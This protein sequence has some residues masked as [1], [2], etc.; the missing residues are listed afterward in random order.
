MR[1]SI[2]IGL[3]IF[4]FVSLAAV[5][6]SEAHPTN[7][8]FSR[9]SGPAQTL[10]LNSSKVPS[11]L[12]SSY[13]NNVS[14]NITTNLGNSVNLSFVNARTVNGGFVELANHGKIHNFNDGNQQVTGIN[15]I[16]FTGS[17]SFTF[18]PALAGGILPDITPIS[19]SA[20]GGQ[21]SIPACDYFE[22][23]AGD[24]GA[25]ITS[26][27]L[28]YSC[29]S[30]DYNVKL[31]NGTYTGKGGS[32]AYTYK[33]TIND[34]SAT[35]VSL[36]KQTNTSL[37]GTATMSSKTSL[38]VALTNLTYNFTYDGHALTYVS[39]SGSSASS[40]PEL[41]L[42]R[43]Y[44]VENFES[45]SIT[46]QGYTNS[47]TK[48]QTTGLRSAFYAD[49]YTGSSSGEIGGSGWPIMTSSDNT[50]YGGT[51]GHNGS[52][53][54]IFKFS[55]G[56]SMRYYSMNS[57]YGV[58][59]TIGRGTTISLWARGAYTNTSFNVNHGSD[60][61]MKLF[62]YFE[63]PVNSSNQQ[64]GRETFEF[65]VSN[66]SIWQHFEFDLD[67]SKNYYSFALFG[68]QSSGSTQ[69]V[70]I[71]DVEIYSESPYAEYTPPYPSGTY[72]TTVSSYKLLIS[73]GTRGNG[74]FAVRI[75]TADINATSL[76]YNDQNNSFSISTNGKVG[77]YTVGTI[78]GTYNYSNDTLTN[79]NCSGQ[80]GQAVSNVTLSHPT[81]GAY[82]N[83]DQS[84]SELQNTFTRRYRSSGG[85]WQRDT[86]SSD[87]ILSNKVYNAAGKSGV[88]IRPCT[89]TNDAYG[90][91]LSSDYSSPK[92]LT[93]IQFWVYN[94]C[95]YD[96][97][98]RI[99]YFKGQ[100]CSDNGQV[101]LGSSDIAKANSWNYVSRGMANTAQSIY[102][103]N[104]S[105]WTADQTQTNVTMSARLVFD[106]I[107]FW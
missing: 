69:Y 28:S 36:D 26:L 85:D 72:I 25:S 52:K 45:Y 51:H 104:I 60:T 1:K 2:S 32:P 62:A 18:K 29:N 79:V 38:Q 67:Q 63:T 17:G 94:P 23:E 54:G 83:C 43:V 4:G 74:L 59:R 86:S 61:P 11:G 15:G 103:F 95:D 47:T 35:L 101:G 56:S 22:I 98:F 48:Y 87:R 96:I 73:F 14:A 92:S 65:S 81:N 71:D 9:A 90:F 93:D 42:K 21:V 37:S 76:S 105:V 34:G 82:Y 102:N 68:Q 89:N 12:T 91:V 70:P 41:S 106:D 31:V 88:S 19:V 33:L 3:I 20:G 40:Y 78:S 8:V 84:T 16:S 97:K 27:S 7:L 55:N 100:N 66:G 64:S 107:Y 10:T 50:N 44:F 57:L 80:I 77:G 30:A 49:Y 24:S 75:S 6:A 53:A 39:K 5:V 58:K 99:Y 13:Q 46:G